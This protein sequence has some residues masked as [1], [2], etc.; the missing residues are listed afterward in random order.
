M[1][2]LEEDIYKELTAPHE[3]FE[4]AAVNIAKTCLQ[5]IEKAYRDGY[6][7]SEDL[8]PAK[9]KWLRENNL[10]SS[11][12]PESGVIASNGLSNPP[13]EVKI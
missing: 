10:S 1:N 9:A 3:S 2:K 6:W 11:P 12:E 5:W 13:F 4:H 8:E 7:E